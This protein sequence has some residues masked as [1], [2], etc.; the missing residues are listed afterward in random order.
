MPKNPENLNP[1]KEKAARLQEAL[2]MNEP[3]AVAYYLKEDLR[4]IWSQPNKDTA[5]QVIDDWIA[6]VQASGFGPLVK[7]AATLVNRRFGILAGNDHRITSGPM[8]GTNNK[9]KTLKWRPTA[10]AT[11]NSSNSGSWA[12]IRRSTL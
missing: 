4:Q 11:W 7:I 10:S 2:K 6:R 9:I 12:S 8:E 3:L 1:G 5:E